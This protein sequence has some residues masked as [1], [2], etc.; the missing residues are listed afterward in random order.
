MSKILS[1]AACN[2]DAHILRACYPLFQE[3]R[4]GAIEWSFD[5]LF[6]IKQVPEWFEELLYVYS[7]ANRLIGHG[8]FFSLFS[9]KWL[10]EQQHWLDVLRQTRERFPLEQVTEHFGFMTGSNFHD[11]APLAIPYS[12]GTLRIGQ[13]RLK[14]IQDAAQCPAGLENLAFA[15]SLEEVRRHG[16]FLS[17][18][19][20]PVNGFIILDLHNIYCQAENFRLSAV[21]MLKLYPLDRV[22]EMHI[23]GGSWETVSLA[24]TRR[25]RRDT[26]DDSVP[27]Q[28]FELL[29]MALDVCQHCRY[30]VLE[31]L[32]AGLQTPDSRAQFYADFIQMEKIVDEANLRRNNTEQNNFLPLENIISDSVIEDDRLYMQQRELSAILES[33]MNYEQAVTALHASSL[34]HTEWNIEHWDAAM[35]QTAMSIARKWAQN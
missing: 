19:I 15:Y 13:D 6:Q 9:G 25:I 3:E 18:L 12:A 22:R 20:E 7:S 14:R 11:G 23:S 29:R 31:Q 4:V 21:E 28:V 33:G 27:S 32:G 24:P 1:T 5:A 10:P 34:A 26:H 16:D 17:E 2:L 35:L 8:V 30:V